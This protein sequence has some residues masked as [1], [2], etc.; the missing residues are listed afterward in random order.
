VKC[1]LEGKVLHGVAFSR[2][3]HRSICTK[4]PNPI[5]QKEGVKFPAE[6]PFVW[7]QDRKYFAIVKDMH[8]VF[9]QQTS[10]INVNNQINSNPDSLS[11]SIYSSKA[12]L[13]LFESE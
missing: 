5:F 7:Y 3:S 6:D 11:T 2:F 8:S 10:T 12:S 9:I 4:S 13:V 1:H